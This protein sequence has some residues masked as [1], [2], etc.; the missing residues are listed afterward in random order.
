MWVLLCK[1]KDFPNREPAF[2]GIFTDESQALYAERELNNRLPINSTMQYYLEK[3]V[4]NTVFHGDTL[5]NDM[6]DVQAY[7][8]AYT[9]TVHYI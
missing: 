1:D 6:T 3:P 9:E 4:P 8:G 7:G 5:T 2:K